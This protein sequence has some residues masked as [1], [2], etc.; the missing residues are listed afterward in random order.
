M[1]FLRA[2]RRVKATPSRWE[3]SDDELD[4]LAATRQRRP[5][6]TEMAR[7]LLGDPAQTVDALGLV[8]AGA[9]RGALSNNAIASMI[10]GRRMQRAVPGAALSVDWADAGPFLDT[11]RPFLTDT[12]DALELGC[13][14]GRISRQ[15]APRVRA[16]ACTDVSKTMVREASHNLAGHSNVQCER[17]DGLTLSR[18]ED[19]SADVVFAQGVLTYMDPIPLLATLA[20]VHRVLRPSGACVFNFAVLDA[21]AS[22]TYLLEAARASAHKRRFSAAIERPYSYEQIVAMYRA[23][24]L[25]TPTAGLDVASLERA[26]SGRIDV[27]G[28]KPPEPAIHS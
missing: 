20:E 26:P 25:E 13:G 21:P 2:H 17:V 9:R 16:L 14:D 15:V 23:A 6:R 27:V 8:L 5:S 10:D 24:G 1:R 19:E 7:L 12:T 4:T 28:H 22:A 3:L 18:F 11:L